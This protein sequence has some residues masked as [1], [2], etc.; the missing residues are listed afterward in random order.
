VSISAGPEKGQSMHEDII[1]FQS[2]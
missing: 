1:C 2:G